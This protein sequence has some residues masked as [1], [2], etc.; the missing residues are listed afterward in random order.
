M[1][2]VSENSNMASVNL[3]INKAKNKLENLQT[4]G[5]SLKDVNRPSDNP[6]ASVEAL[7]ISSITSDN[8]QF[9]KNIN[10]ATMQLNISE[11]TLEQLT[12]IMVKA[13]ELAI[14]QAS[15]F[16][17]EKIRKNVSLEITQLRNQAL[18]LANQRLGPRFIFGGHA[19]LK[20]PFDKDGN[21]YGDSGKIN[22]E[23]TKDLFIPINVPGNEVFFA[24][25]KNSGTI[26]SPMQNFPEIKRG[27][28]SDQEAPP[29]EAPVVSRELAS[30][31]EKNDVDNFATRGN[32]FSQLSSF[33]TA[34]ENNDT[35]VIQSLLED[36]DNSISRL[37]TLRTKV[38][39]LNS[40]VQIA[41]NGIEGQTLQL[42]DKKSHLIDADVAEVF[43]DLQKQ[44]QVL[45]T[46]YSSSKGLVNQSLLDFIR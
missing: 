7:S 9:L 8:E 11:S 10:H 15:D 17:D 4:K 18:A 27:K 37:I 5:T 26:V 43:S 36:F 14:G 12:D 40:S 16:Y 35:K 42:E 13:K 20:P 19:T 33:V 31:D 24:S 39:S 25:E 23:V 28:A 46:T 29:E 32:I 1:T 38:G 6:I 34:L 2:R 21:Y 30:V 41:K 22:L 45:K 3:A 44:Q